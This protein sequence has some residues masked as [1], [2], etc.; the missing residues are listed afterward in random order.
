MWTELK[1]KKI[2][3][4]AVSDSGNFRDRELGCL[5]LYSVERF[6]N[7]KPCSG[8]SVDGWLMVLSSCTCSIAMLT[9]I[10]KRKAVELFKITFLQLIFH[11][12]EGVW[13]KDIKRSMARPPPPF[14]LRY[15]LT[16]YVG[17][18]NFC[19]QKQGRFH[20]HDI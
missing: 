11:H 3:S 6:I 7:K 1:K 10:Q 12:S 19:L 20:V 13:I 14:A 9:Y 5:G 2:T 8:Y 18:L 17:V 16:K 4:A 15:P